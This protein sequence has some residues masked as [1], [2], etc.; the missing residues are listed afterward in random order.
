[1]TEAFG[2]LPI[3]LTKDAHASMLRGMI[4]AAGDGATPYTELLEA[5]RQYSDLEV[6]IKG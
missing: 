3:R 1:M 2:P 6:G 5:L 4:A